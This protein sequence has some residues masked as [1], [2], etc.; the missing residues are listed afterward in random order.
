[1]AQRRP[2]MAAN[3]KMYKTQAE[4]M[5]FW[6]TF[7]GSSAVTSGDATD[8]VICAPAIYLPML[9]QL[10]AQL[11]AAA[12]LRLAAQTMANAEEGAFT[13][14][15]SPRQL[16]DIGVDTVVIGHS[17]RRTYYNETDTTV[18]EKTRLALKHQLLPIVCVGETQAE[19]EAGQTDAVVSRQVKA[20][21]QGIDT[22]QLAT[23]VFAYEPVWAIGT[24]KVCDA[25]EA[26]RVCGLVREWV[27]QPA[28]RVLYGGSVKPD[29]VDE[30]MAQP[31]ID[32]GLVG[33]ASLDATSFIKLIQ[34]A[35]TQY[36]GAT[37]SCSL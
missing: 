5:A 3:W 25:Q 15:I 14:E 37:S 8:R 13:G 12:Q 28:T 11:P 1:M 17:E 9:V 10:R 22:S 32:G 29:N 27:G 7:K 19:R 6:E 4:I 34:A 24:G 16:V 26:N 30:L 36:A 20:A 21:I 18:N 23:L 33:G 35:S 2:M 31:H